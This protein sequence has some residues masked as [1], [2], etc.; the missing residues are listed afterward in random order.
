[1]KVSYL[2]ILILFL[3]LSGC[4]TDIKTFDQHF[5]NLQASTS[6]TSELQNATAL[7]DYATDEH[8]SY[9]LEIKDVET[10]SP[11]RMDELEQAMSKKL[12]VTISVSESDFQAIWKPVDNSNIFILLRE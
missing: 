10:S 7:N 6:S 5:K 12:S 9:A 8:L 4:T 3:F 11:I 1:M 2:T